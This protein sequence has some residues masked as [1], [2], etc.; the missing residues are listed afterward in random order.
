M[1]NILD[2]T[3]ITVYTRDELISYFTTGFQQI[4]GSDINLASDTPD[5]QMINLFVQS[6]LDSQDLMVQIFNS[7]DPDNA[8]GNVLDQRVAING[9]QRQAGTFTV[10][11]ITVVTTQSVN[12]Y[13]LDQS[14]QTV[15][16]V[17]DAAGN[18]WQLQT[19]VLG[20]GTGTF[21]YDFQAAVPGAQL[22]IPNT[23]TVQVTIVLGVQSV[24]NPTTYTTLGTNEETDAALK[25]RRQRSVSLASQGYLAGLLAA[26]LNIPGMSSAF[27]YEND[28]DSTDSDG[29]PS[30]SIWVITAG[31]AAVASIAQAIYDKR[32]AGCGMF[33]AQSYDITQVDNT[34]FTVYWDDVVPVNL[35]IA[36]TATSINGTVAPNINAIRTD[37]PTDFVPA[38][39]EE[40]N[41]NGMATIVQ[42]IDSNTLVTSA[43]FTTGQT[44]IMTL[45]GVAASGAFKVNY[46]GVASASIAWNDAIGTIQTKVRAITGLSTVVV[47]GSI[48]SQTLHFDLSSITSVLGL[49]YITNNTLQTSAPAAITFSFNEG[50]TNT[51][52]PSSKKYQFVVSS[53]NI[54]ILLMILSPTSSTVARTTGTVSFQAYGGYGTYTYSILT[55]NSGGSINASTGV[56]TAGSTPNVTDTI[57]AVDVFGNTATATVAVV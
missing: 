37:L 27:V 1:P 19:T 57:Q 53:D 2:A 5:G 38:V 52:T 46:N 24:N 10:T 18:L 36:F 21:V 14:D 50:Y 42:Q 3:G 12:L 4:Y 56:Y 9:I 43:G 39:F 23:I 29:V 15:Y 33:G 40:V 41:I 26:L 22:T 8:I 32:N 13:G 54:Y 25:I 34:I 31:S 17:S 30:H 28:T 11:P 51:L 55:N 7:F 48:A 20:T 16:T 44:Q 47:T 45:S 6:V 35:F 49:L